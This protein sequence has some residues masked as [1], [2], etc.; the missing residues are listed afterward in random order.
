MTEKR[1]RTRRKDS[2]PDDIIKV[3]LSL[4]VSK[5][6]YKT[7]LAD[8]AQKAGIGRSTI[9]LY[10]DD[11][12]DLLRKAV[13]QKFVNN[14]NNFLETLSPKK[15]DIRELVIL[16]TNFMKKIYIDDEKEG[17]Y[18]LVHCLAISD[19][20]IAQIWKS[21]VIDKMK[22]FWLGLTRE[23]GI[24]ADDAEFYSTLLFSLFFSSLV[25]KRSLG[26]NNPLMDFETLLSQ[27]IKRIH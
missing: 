22:S 9:Y 3:A 12:N 23:N 17:F 15:Q 13:Q 6:F 14:R 21:E 11:K 10:F 4:F 27:L 20:Q 26:A 8:I 16:A 25:C 7:T 5:G 2:R 18:S 19:P 24:S 1:K